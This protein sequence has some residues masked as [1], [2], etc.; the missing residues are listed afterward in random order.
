MLSNQP[1]LTEL[2][3]RLK[4]TTPD[5][6]AEWIWNDTNENDI[7]MRFLGDVTLTEED[8]R[9]PVVAYIAAHSRYWLYINGVSVVREGG[10]KR[11]RT[12]DT[13][14]YDTLNLTNYLKSGT[15]RIA[16]EV[17]YWGP[18]LSMSYAST[19]RAALY[20]QMEYGEKTFCSDESWRVRHDT[21]FLNWYNAANYRL[22]EKDV[23]YLAENEEPWKEESFDASGWD[24]AVSYGKAGDLPFGEML[25]R[26]IPL[27]SD[28]GIRQYENSADYENYTLRSGGE[29]L[30]L[31]LSYNA[32][33]LPRLSIDADAA[34]LAIEILTDQY[35]DNNGNSVR[36]VYVTKAGAQEFECPAWMNGEV[37]RYRIPEGVRVKELSYREI[38]YDTEFDG[39]FSCND[40][41]YN[42]LWEKARRTLYVNMHDTYMDC[43]NRERALWFADQ[44]LEMYEAA[45][46]L[47]KN[48]EALFYTGVLTEYGWRQEDGTLLVPIPTEG[49]SLEMPIQ[50]L[51]GISAYWDAYLYS[52]DLSF[53]QEIY[54]PTME[55]LKDWTPDAEGHVVFE[56]ASTAWRW[57]DSTENVDYTVLENAWYY[58]DLTV[59]DR[60]AQELGETADSAF[61][62]ER[63]HTV[64]DGFQSFWT[65]QGYMS[66]EVTEPDERA[67][68]LAVLS[69]LAGE[70]RYE[71]IAEIFQ[72]SFY[73]TPLLEYYVES[74]CMAVG[75]PDLAELRI[76]RQYRDMIEGVHAKEASTL[77]EYWNYGQGTSNHAWSGGPL[78]LLSEDFAGIRPTA[79]GY[80]EFEVKPQMGSLSEISCVVPTTH[81]KIM[82]ILSADEEEC[83][84]QMELTKPAGETARVAVPRMGGETTV[85]INGKT[86]SDFA[87]VDEDYL[88]MEILSED[89]FAEITAKGFE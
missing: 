61:L 88:Y 11:G 58:Y 34:G 42:V 30:S 32:Q 43:P 72:T 84:F 8:L 51:M 14:Y 45:Y 6:K 71:T 52:G 20:F 39:S 10:Q 50:I 17:W 18:G 69:G 28:Y 68:A 76:K 78:V 62:E 37:V 56:R 13:I 16:V 81:G 19:G 79:P 57:A 25:P 53:L 49:S 40:D 3:D 80:A 4:G 9:D 7:W 47:G 24:Y 60:I 2:P 44:A 12:Q 22:A 1:D 86:V 63:M 74:A 26:S 83:L 70:D 87:E 21:A 66:G 27:F 46:C 65:A 67:N 33:L 75:R 54:E 36:A 23:Y 5:W 77:W 59:M 15:N 82:V 35:E 85:T 89:A 38:G 41:F 55:Y 29:E 73:A 31:R 64:G 48:K